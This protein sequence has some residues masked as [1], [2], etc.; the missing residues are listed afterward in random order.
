MIVVPSWP[1]PACVRA[2]VTER[3]GGVSSGAYASLNL[4]Q[5][6]GDAPIAV[7]ENRARLQNRLSLPS[8]PRWLNQ[9]HGIA[10][11]D[12]DQADRVSTGDT[13]LPTADAAVTRRPGVVCCVMT[14]DC[15]PIFLCDR[16]GKAVG[17]AHAGWRGLAAGVVAAT[18][19]AMN[20]DPANLLAYLGPAISAAAFEV[21]PEVRDAFIAQDS[22]AAE[23]FCANDRGR[24]QAD[25]YLLARQALKTVGV[26]VVY[27]GE[28][29][30]F[31]DTKCFFS[32]RR[33][34][35]CGRMASLIW[36]D[37]AAA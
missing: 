3:S 1:A 8:P 5:H 20:I 14:A 29:C 2:Y 30:T 10:V 23:A 6:V 37:P 7:A 11:H 32:H 27:G 15:L 35:P 24:W 17:L 19:N 25:L 4:A 22:N 12:I 26:S 33:S 31:T 28:A 36:I 9:V 16:A 34:A 18:V 13:S 21:G